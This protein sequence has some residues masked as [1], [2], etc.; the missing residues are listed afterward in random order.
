MRLFDRASAAHGAEYTQ[1]LV[2]T[3]DVIY[4]SSYLQLRNTYNLFKLVS[5][6]R[7]LY[8]SNKGVSNLTYEEVWG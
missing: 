8:L 3:L 7:N 2:N 6:S 1:E 5:P 4:A